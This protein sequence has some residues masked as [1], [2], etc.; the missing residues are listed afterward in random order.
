MRVD[1]RYQESSRQE[2]CDACTPGFFTKE[3]AT[4]QLSCPSSIEN[5]RPPLVG[6]LSL[7]PLT[8]DVP[9]NT[10]FFSRAG[11]GECSVC[12]ENYVRIP[13]TSDVNHPE[14]D[15]TI[16]WECFDCARN[17]GVWRYVPEDGAVCREKMTSGGSEY[18]VGVHISNLTIRPG[19]WRESNT[20][21]LIRPCPVDEGKDIEDILAEDDLWKREETENGVEYHNQES[22]ER[23]KLACVGNATF[24]HYCNSGHTGPLC[25]CNPLNACASPNL[26]MRSHCSPRCAL[27]GPMVL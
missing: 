6:G 12:G 24:G 23:V 10:G 3:N 26:T 14:G 15:Y 8:S 22:D 18:D 13:G 27:P 11:S 19:Y 17:W 5:G 16:G 25:E 1:R 2:D 21:L 4:T 7:E 20:T 9:A